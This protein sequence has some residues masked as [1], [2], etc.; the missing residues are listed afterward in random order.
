MPSDATLLFRC[1]KCYWWI[2][3]THTS[4]EPLSEVQLQQKTFDLRCPAPGCGWT[5][6]LSGRDALPLSGP[7]PKSGPFTLSPVK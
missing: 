3:G 7:V 5:G 2:V 6:Q 1:P 4:P